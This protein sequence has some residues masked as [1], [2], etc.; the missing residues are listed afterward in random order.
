MGKI[1]QL[2]RGGLV[3][4][5]VS[6]WAAAFAWAATP[7]AAAPTPTG[8]T[9]PFSADYR[10]GADDTLNIAVFQVGDLSRTVHVDSSGNILMPLIGQVQAAG[11]TPSQL[12]DVI[13]ADLR[14]KYMKDPQV[15]VTVADS[16]SQKITVD[17]AVQ[18]PGIYSLT[19]PTT[20]IQAV[21]MASGTDPKLANTKQ[22][23]VFRVV[24]GAR[25]GQVYNLTSI[26]K[27]H[28]PDPPVYGRDIV[29]VPAS[30]GKTF[31]QYATQILP[32]MAFLAAF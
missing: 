17:G 14:R 25:V 5:A 28:A 19:G 10:I 12:S 32:G 15:T 11:R 3:A 20:L 24:N 26:R 31:L 29:V 18:K 27:G 21:A 7:P 16:T 9:D 6:F 8:Y 4:I 13:A 30:G 22:V 1:T 23:E 2:A